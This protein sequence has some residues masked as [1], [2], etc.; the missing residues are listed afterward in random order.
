MIWMAR[1]KMRLGA[2]D[3]D[4]EL[5]G[6]EGPVAIIGPNGAGKSTVLRTIAGAHRPDAGFI[7]L[8]SA[9]VF[10]SDSAIDLAPEHRRVADRRV[11]ALSGGE[12]QRVALARALVTSPRILLLDEPLAAL[13]AGARPARCAS[14]AARLRSVPSLLITHDARDVFAL[15]AQVYVIE[16]GRVVQ[17]GPVA[18]VAGRPVTDFGAEFFAALE[19]LTRPGEPP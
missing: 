3:L 13:D 16:D 18:E 6:S 19:P 8:G 12:A 15:A 9:T 17:S 10:D 5:R 7:S 11:G 1:I 2:L 14:C 4:V